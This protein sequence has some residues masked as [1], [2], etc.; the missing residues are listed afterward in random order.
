MIPAADPGMDALAVI[1]EIADTCWAMAIAYELAIKMFE[2]V[3]QSPPSISD[4][5]TVAHEY[6]HW[7]FE[8]SCD[9][10]NE[11][12]LIVQAAI[13]LCLLSFRASENYKSREKLFERVARSETFSVNDEN[14]MFT[15]QNGH[16]Y[17]TTRID[18]YKAW[19][20]IHYPTTT[21]YTK[22]ID[23]N[24]T[25]TADF[26]EHLEE[27]WS[28]TLINQAALQLCNA[29]NTITKAADQC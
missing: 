15:L 29:V 19:H 27:N 23:N 28:D 21:L 12:Y 16:K 13:E 6:G 7:T 17:G 20:T 22:G 1:S 26:Y 18:L 9:R 14:N 3:V 4:I 24:C 11:S 8:A 5:K 25:D 10:Y 2:E